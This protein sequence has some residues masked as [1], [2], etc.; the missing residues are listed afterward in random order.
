MLSLFPDLYIYSNIVPLIFRFILAYFFIKIAY[1]NYLFLKNTHLGK[2]V[3][4]ILLWSIVPLVGGLF[5]VVGIFVQPV[6]LVFS[7][8]ILVLINSNRPLKLG[9]GVPAFDFHLFV[10]AVLLSLVFLGP[11]ILSIDLP[12]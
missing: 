3:V 8:I 6:S 2:K 11:G 7:L 12:L 4:D 1:H 10:L 9:L 5:F